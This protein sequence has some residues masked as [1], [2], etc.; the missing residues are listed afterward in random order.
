MK[1]RKIIVE[2]PLDEMMGGDAGTKVLYNWLYQEEER[3]Y[4]IN[5]KAN[6]KVSDSLPDF[7]EDEA[8]F[9]ESASFAN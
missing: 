8:L 1:S 7:W 9:V 4:Y 5:E 2:P 6:E 3:N